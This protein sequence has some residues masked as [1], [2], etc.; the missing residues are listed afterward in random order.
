[1]CGIYC[2]TNGELKNGSFGEHLL[3]LR[4]PNCLSKINIEQFNFSHSLLSI[5]GNFK[6]QPYVKDNIVC[7]YNGEIY[8]TSYFGTKYYQY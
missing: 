8:N 4:G 7:L 6:F 3:K 1:M 2:S 5:T